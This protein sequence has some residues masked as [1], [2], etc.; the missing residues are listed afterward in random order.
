MEPKHVVGL[1]GGKDSTAM[2]LRL[3]EVEPR[4]YEFICNRTGNELQVLDD[5]LGRL[6]E[7]LGKPIKYVGTGDDLYG[8][9]GK[10]KMLPN[11]QAR[12]CTRILK[13]E[14][15]IEYFE[16]LPPGSTLYVGLRADEDER[17]GLY[18][19]DL[20]VDFPFRRWGWGI[21]RVWSY[22]KER[23]V[24]VPNRTDCDVC[25]YQRLGEWY[26][27]WK[28]HPLRY[29]RG[30]AWEHRLGHTFRSPQRDTWPASLA[31]LAHEFA[32]GRVPKNSDKALEEF[33]GQQC[34]VC[35][36]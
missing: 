34:R 17:K 3:A 12:F 10:I 36:L 35:R 1:S 15:T 14:P 11:F 32:K 24:N 2:A 6:E 16:S 5:H 7:L 9:I 13:I 18:G 20:Q 8:L 22:L 19:E 4:D 27:L 33:G 23:G 29:F 25:P 28:N 31:E 21:D 26:A 30:V